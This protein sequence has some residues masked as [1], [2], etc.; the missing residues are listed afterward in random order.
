MAYNDDAVLAKLSSLSETQDSIVSVAQWIMFY[1]RHADRTVQLWLQKLKDSSSHKRLNLVYLANEVA[2]QS[3]ARRK[4]EFLVSFSPAV[5]EAVAVAYKGAPHDVQQ[6]IRRVVDVWRERGVFEGPIQQAVEARIHDLDKARGTTKAG[7]G[8]GSIFGSASSV[9]AELAS[10]VTPQQNVSKVVLTTKPVVKSANTDYD[11]LMAPGST[12]PSAPVY[13]AR[14]SGLLKTIAQAEGAVEQCVKARR[15]LVNEL[16]KL[17]DTNRNA[18][19]E[20]ENELE[21]VMQKKMKAEDKKTEVERAIMAGLPN[22]EPYPTGNGQDDQPAADMDRP[23]VEALTPP[24]NDEG[25]FEPEPNPVP[26]WSPEFP[27]ENTF[28]A[29]PAPATQTLQDIS[30]PYKSVATTSNGSKKRRLDDTSDFPDLGGDDIDADVAEMLR[31][32][33]GS[34]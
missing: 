18:L 32:D 6:R 21:N 23:E 4:E 28:P 15:V 31:K 8:G 17:L 9:P 24:S 12:V 5:A 1:R 13:A 25:E 11:S 19:I 2:Q 29:H 10:L 33:S 30:S 22:D 20:D 3:K 7:L 26:E 14:L 27:P 16:Q 34:N